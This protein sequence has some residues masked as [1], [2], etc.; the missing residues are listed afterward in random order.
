M[1]SSIITFDICT[2]LFAFCGFF[3]RGGVYYDTEY[4]HF[5]HTIKVTNKN[6]KSNTELLFRN[7][8]LKSLFF[9]VSNL[10]PNTSGETCVEF[11][12]CSNT[13]SVFTIRKVIALTINSCE[14]SA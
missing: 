9:I 3:W 4:T 2:M 7:V 8:F 11:V 1:F 13:V 12:C 5:E 6:F 10:K 14:D